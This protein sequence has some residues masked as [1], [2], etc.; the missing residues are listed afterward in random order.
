VAAIGYIASVSGSTVVLVEPPYVCWD[1][2][3]DRVREGEE[4]IPGIGTLVLAAVARTRGHRVHVVDGKRTGTPVDAVAERVAALRPDHVGISATTIS[5]HNAAR[6]AERLKALVP[7]AAITVG[8]PH[9]SAVPERTLETF[10][11]FDYGIVGEGE[12]S[13][14][15]LIAR[16]EAGADPRAV[17]G[18]VWRDGGAVRANP[19]AAYLDGDELDQLP[20]P[21]WDLVPDFPL[22]FQPNVFNYRATPVASVVTSRGCPFSCTFCDRS[23]S[24]RRGRYHSADYVVA[25]C[26]RLERL[27]VRHILFYDDLFT[28]KHSRVVALCERFLA[29]GFRFTWSCNSH[30]NLLD[31][32]TLALM[33]RAGCWQIA[34]GIE[35]GSQ[36]VL[37]LVKHEV[38]IP[39][40][41]ETLRLTRAAGIQVKG[42]FMMGHP[43]ETADTLEETIAFLRTAPLDLAQVTKFTPYPGTPSYAGIRDWGTFHEDWER[44]NAMNWVFVPRG[45]TPELLERAFRRAYTAFYG[46]PDVLWGL[47][48]TLAGEPRFL[49]RMATYIRVGVRDWLLVRPTA[50]PGTALAS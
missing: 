20:E 6:I 46:R 14:F 2:R 50:D 33:R 3:S 8:G 4:E 18:L 27:G 15:D 42:L 49:R 32:P 26:R 21:A 48:R 12:R 10:A 45:L 13:W 38:R 28:V 9:V 25:M 31:A 24:G 34:Y 44:M 5:I 37:D 23:T 29:E 35:S 16:L 11:G 30:P 47:V 1:R 41:L 36:R 43:N 19:R 40:M 22:R 7:G 17:E 39:R